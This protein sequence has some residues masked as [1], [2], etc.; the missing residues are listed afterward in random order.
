M[1]L[2]FVR[3]VTVDGQAFKVGEVVEVG[4]EK[5]DYFASCLRMGHAKKIEQPAAKAD[6][7]RTASK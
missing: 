3:A 5:A 4:G 6:E 2:E 1:K 7:K